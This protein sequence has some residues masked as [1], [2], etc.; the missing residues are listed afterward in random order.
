MG[1]KKYAAKLDDYFER[2]K[3]GKAEKIKKS[4]VDKVIRKLEAKKLQLAEE[5]EETS[6]E[7]KK[8][9]LERKMLIAGEHL[10]RAEMLLNTLQPPAKENAA[11]SEG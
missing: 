7:S 3:E 9:R 10:K 1:L 4:H 11:Q 2:L 5:I 6:K 8:A